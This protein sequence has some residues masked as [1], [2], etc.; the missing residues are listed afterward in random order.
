MSFVNGISTFINPALLVGGKVLAGEADCKD[1]QIKGKCIIIQTDH[2]EFKDNI[3]KSL[4]NSG[5]IRSVSDYVIISDDVILVCEMKS[6]NEGNMK[7]QLKNTG[8]LVKYILS[9][10][11]LHGKINVSIPPI[12]YVCFANMYKDQ[13]QNS[14]GKFVSIP[15][16]DGTLLKLPCNSNYHLS[17]FI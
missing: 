1:I 11:G 7:T 6:N 13:K 4:F 3:L 12:V 8:Q 2:K 16:N 15:W 10:I 9:L 14:S 17:Q 5:A